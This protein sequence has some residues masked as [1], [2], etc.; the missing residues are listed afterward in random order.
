MSN[1]A[2]TSDR[3]AMIETDTAIAAT[4][5][6]VAR[7]NANLSYWDKRASQFRDGQEQ[8]A[9]AAAEW[10]EAADAYSTADEAYEG[11][12]RF[13]AVPGGHLHSSTRCSTCNNGNAP[14]V[15]VWVPALAGLTEIEAV[16]MFGDVLCTICFPSAPVETCGGKFGTTIETKAQ[17]DD[18]RTAAADKKAAKAAAATAKSITG[19]AGQNLHG[20]ECNR[21]R[22]ATIAQAKTFLTDAAQWTAGGRSHPSFPAYD[23]KLVSEALAARTGSDAATEVAAAAKRAAK[24]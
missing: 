11:W 6:A 24:R 23:V 1:T 13:Y 19:T 21:T 3:T 22:V 9:K 2:T 5:N 18:K 14:T 10:I 16:A 12:A 8:L 20:F 17:R 4:A 7:A 15:F